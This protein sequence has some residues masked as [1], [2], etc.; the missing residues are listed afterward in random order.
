M[1]FILQDA[2]EVQLEVCIVCSVEA[3]PLSLIWA[4]P[5]A[6]YLYC[7]EQIQAPLCEVPPWAENFPAAGTLQ[8]H[9]S[10]S[11]ILSGEKSLKKIY[12]SP[13]SFTFS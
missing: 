7:M 9:H 5:G 2:A 3:F 11:L 4:F 10:F 8:E 6:E 13:H 12:F 1:K